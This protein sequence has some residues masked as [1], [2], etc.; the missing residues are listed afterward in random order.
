MAIALA[1]CSGASSDAEPDAVSS[2]DTSSSSSTSTSLVS[3][4][5]DST[6]GW[7]DPS[8]PLCNPYVEAEASV[9]DGTRRAWIAQVIHEPI[10]GPVGAPN[11]Y[12]R[13]D[14]VSE[15]GELEPNAKQ[16]EWGSGDFVM[17]ASASYIAVAGVVLGLYTTD[18]ALANHQWVSGTPR[19]LAVAADGTTYASLA[20]ADGPQIQRDFP[21]EESFYFSLDDVRADFVAP[22]ETGVVTASRESTILRAYERDGAPSWTTEVSPSRRVVSMASDAV[23]TVYVAIRTFGE[24]DAE[25]HRVMLDGAIDSAFFHA[26]PRSVTDVVALAVDET[27][28]LICA[29]T[30]RDEPHLECF[31]STMSSL[32]SVTDT[33]TGVH[34]VDDSVWYTTESHDLVRRDSDGTERWRT[35]VGLDAT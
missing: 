25:L 34:V 10:C 30:M 11:A 16:S 24:P 19:A 32:W 7:P 23:G 33:L 3:E 28:E 27:G 15:D 18:G 20:S 35:R 12:G 6:D 1:G 9:V 22:L 13:I 29:I 31:D 8:G 5:S 17:G 14:F 21:D 26:W 4:E 2:T